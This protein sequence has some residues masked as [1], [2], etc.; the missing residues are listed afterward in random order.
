MNI[1][2]ECMVTELG[3]STVGWNYRISKTQ[4][5]W[6]GEITRDRFAEENLIEAFENDFGWFVIIYDGRSARTICKAVDEE[7]GREI[8]EAL[9]RA[10]K[11]PDRRE[12]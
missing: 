11:S 1:K 12:Q 4:S 8:A 2:L 9:A 5:V 3:G 7:S 10:L 6:C